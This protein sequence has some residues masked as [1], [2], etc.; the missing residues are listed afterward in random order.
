[1]SWPRLGA[2]A[3]S[4]VATKESGRPADSDISRVSRSP[5]GDHGPTC[6]DADS[7][8][9]TFTTP[10]RSE[11]SSPTNSQNAVSTEP[12]P[13][14][15]LQQEVS[16]RLGGLEEAQHA[17]LLERAQMP[18]T[19]T[20][21]LLPTDLA[22]LLNPPEPCEPELDRAAPVP[23][24]LLRPPPSF[25]VLANGPFKLKDRGGHA[26]CIH[27]LNTTFFFGHTTTQCTHAH[28]C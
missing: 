2:D 15:R 16:T 22:M 14:K 27:E 26:I 20:Q 28:V 21:E 3:D 7:W 10:R 9:S 1:M 4:L 6:K 18:V 17:A 25:P 5:K 11:R 23:M 12:E 24:T 8:L 19:R 13:T